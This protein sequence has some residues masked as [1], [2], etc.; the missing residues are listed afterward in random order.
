MCHPPIIVDRCRREP[1]REGQTPVEPYTWYP[2]LHTVH[3]FAAYPAICSLLHK[4]FLDLDP[5]DIYAEGNGQDVG[6]SY[7]DPLR[8]RS[9]P[10]PNDE[11]HDAKEYLKGS[12]TLGLEGTFNRM[13]R[14][15]KSYLYRGKVETIQS[16]IEQIEAVQVDDIQRSAHELLDP[17]RQTVTT[18]GPADETVLRNAINRTNLE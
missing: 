14:L 8:V 6:E 2:G 11:L 13:S 10:V 17:A 15:A 12:I 16:I 7:S 9:E 1:E 5:A 4:Q 3:L 18:F